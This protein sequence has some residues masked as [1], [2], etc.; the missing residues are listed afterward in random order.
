M[1]NWCTTTLN[2]KGEPVQLEAFFDQ[3]KN[4][5]GGDP[6]TTGYEI[7]STYYPLPQA[8]KESFAGFYGD[9]EKQKKVEEEWA[10]NVELYGAKNWYDWCWQNWGT[11]WGDCDTELT[12]SLEDSHYT[13]L[14]FYLQSAWSPISEGI[15][16]VSTLFPNLYFIMEHREES[17]EYF[18]YEVIHNGVQLFE[19]GF[20]DSE[21]EVDEPTEGDDN[22]NEYYDALQEARE[23][24]LQKHA[25]I[26]YNHL[27]EIGVPA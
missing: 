5:E 3:I 23:E 16:V 27:S 17:G 1:P 15:K 20:S 26:F 14:S 11:K 12:T 24:A 9:E 8:L 22:Y 4:P 21:L 6:H 18:F 7:L 10:Q 13:E 19:T 25:V 2:I